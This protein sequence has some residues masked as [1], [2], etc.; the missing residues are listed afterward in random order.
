MARIE[1]ESEITGRVWKIVTE[2]GT[3]VSEGDTLL[4]LESMKM[5]IPLESPCS[6]TVRELLLNEGDSVNEDQVVAIV[7]TTT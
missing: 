2:T 4:I 1:V 7:D 5:E 6:G 3:K